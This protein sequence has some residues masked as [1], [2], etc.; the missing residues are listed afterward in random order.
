LHNLGIILLAGRKGYWMQSLILAVST[1]LFMFFTAT[2]LLTLAT[3]D[4]TRMKRRLQVLVG[5]EEQIRPIRNKKQKRSRIPVSRVFAE[6]LSSA[7]VRMR[8]E[9]FLILWLAAALVPGGLLMLVGAHPITMLAVAITGVLVP[10]LMVLKS[11]W[12]TPCC[13]WATAC[14]PAS[15]SSRLW[16]T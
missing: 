3:Q 2:L 8:P 7:G 16:P 13:L 11:S 15:L 12:E 6:E 1:T 14:A 10:P 5:Q 4:R 9:E